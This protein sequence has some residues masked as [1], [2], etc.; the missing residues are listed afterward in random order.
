M[1]QVNLPAVDTIHSKG[2]N[3]VMDVKIKATVDSKLNDSFVSVMKI[4]QGSPGI[5]KDLQFK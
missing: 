5:L 1:L 3:S 2:N 4:F